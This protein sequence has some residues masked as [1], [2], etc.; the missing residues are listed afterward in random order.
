MLMQLAT[1]ETQPVLELAFAAYRVNNGY[2][3]D[4]QKWAEDPNDIVIANKDLVKYSLA[5]RDP[6][7]GFHYPA[8]FVPLVVTEEDRENV[9]RAKKHFRKY[10]L[11][12][13]AGTLTDFQNSMF[14][15]IESE[16]MIK[17]SVGIAAYMPEMIERDVIEA[18][19]K[20]KMKELKISSDFIREKQ[21]EGTV[22]VIRVFYSKEFSIY[23]HLANMNGNL[24][25]FNNGVKFPE[26]TEIKIRGKVKDHGFSKDFDVKMTSLNYV[27]IEK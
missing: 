4:S 18:E 15:I 20:A 16:T 14:K 12:S 23:I 13:I 2:V 7:L 27:K 19:Y 9:E 8:G 11:G 10:V 17:N 25:K 26:G 6:N 22:T 5:V 3:K 24:V 1:I 21:T